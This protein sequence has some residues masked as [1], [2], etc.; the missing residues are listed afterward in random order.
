VIKRILV[1]DND[2]VCVEILGDILGQEGYEVVK[3]FDGMEAME[4]LGRGDLPDVVFLDIVMPRIDGD[5]V[6]EYMRAKPQ[7]KQIPVVILSGTMMEDQT[8]ILAMG[9]DGYVAKGPRDSLC[10]N[11]LATLRRL[12]SGDRAVDAPILGL[13]NL[14][15]HEKVRELLA[16]RQRRKAMLEAIEQ[17]IVE[18]DGRGWVIAVNRAGLEILKRPELDL[19]GTPVAEVLGVDYRQTM[20]GA[21]T[22]FLGSRGKISAPVTLRYR[23]RVIEVRFAWNN[24]GD[25]EAGF[26]VLLQDVT[27]L[28][29]KIEALT[30]LNAKL[31]TIDRVRSEF[32]T[33]VSHDLHTPLTAIKGSLDVLLH[34]GVGVELTRELLGIAQKNADR[35]FRLVSD[36]LDLARI[37][38]GRFSMQRE[39]FDV[40]VTLRGTL[41]RLMR[42][43]QE[44]G[45]TLTLQAPDGLSLVF[46]DG[47]RME[48]VFTNL[49]GN[50]LKFTPSGGRIGV[51]VKE[52]ATELLV[53]IRD[54]GVGIPTE[55]LDRVF[56]RFYRVPL[57][58]G[59]EV[60]GT[61]LGLSICKAVVE[62]HG[63]RIW[64]E[65]VVGKGTA[66]YLTI[67]K[68]PRAS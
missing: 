9:A 12:E 65:S 8:K 24:P 61:G 38:E 26:F 39:P 30:T 40:V 1:V 67:P 51:M 3:A 11:V 17:G 58:A 37:E 66:F 19:I 6:F 28:A 36:I 2:Q 32:L 21:L 54:S 62:E 22:R 47:L 42:I 41:D 52:L 44:K 29:G 34:E 64:V 49:L 13:E 23:Q 48:Q 68:A 59:T 20:E 63:G 53:E 4:V 45:I 10:R 60:E 55:H 50:A 27:D 15:P 31:Q 46:A 18:L 33:M 56:D 14:V 7:T 43:A 57:P 25:A 16:I 5:R 35:L